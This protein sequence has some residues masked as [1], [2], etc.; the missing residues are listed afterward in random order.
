MKRV[1]LW[2]FPATTF[3]SG[4]ETFPAAVAL[5]FAA[6]TVLAACGGSPPPA[7][8]SPSPP[9]SAGEVG[10]RPGDAVRVDIWQEPDLTGEFLVAPEGTVVFPLLGERVVAG[11]APAEVERQLASEYREYLENPSVKVT[12][13]R[14][15]S[16]LGEVRQPSLYMVDA[17]V[18]LTEALAMAGG[19]TPIG[20]PSKITLV[21][22]GT[23][24]AASVDPGQAIGAMPITSGDQIQVGQRGWFARNTNLVLGTLTSIAVATLYVLYR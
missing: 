14:R 4:T 3:P 19:L 8:V 22:N 2:P 11:K 17:T 15:I 9:G 24:L 20:D 12:A 7:P 10:L 1:K 21:R 18:S 23:V 5:A 16:I 13:L 6:L